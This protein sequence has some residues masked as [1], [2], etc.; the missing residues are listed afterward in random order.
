MHILRSYGFLALRRH[1]PQSCWQ[2]RYI[3]LALRK[4]HMLTC[5]F[6]SILEL[7]I[8]SHN[9]STGCNIIKISSSVSSFTL[10]QRNQK[11]VELS[12]F[13]LV[14]RNQKLVELSAFLRACIKMQGF[15]RASHIYVITINTCIAEDM[16]VIV[17][18]H[19]LVLTPL[20]QLLFKFC[21]TR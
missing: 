10:V 13:T 18:T 21:C 17:R 11:L 9:F 8:Q 6:S 1:S 15:R 20:I 2:Y 7:Y 14:Q 4:P 16:P 3:R 19:E 5:K 12:S